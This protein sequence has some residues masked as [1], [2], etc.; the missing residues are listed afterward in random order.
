[1]KLNQRARGAVAGDVEPHESILAVVLLA[2][3]IGTGSAHSDGS[4]RQGG[5][6]LG[7]PY[8]RELGLD[9]DNPALRG[10][11]INSWL[12]VTDHQLL[13]HRPKATSIRP[14]PGTLIERLDRAGVRL[15]WFDTA[16]LGLS[17][18]V[19]HLELPDRTHVLSATMLKAQLR[20]KPFNDEPFLLVDAFGE[21]ATEVPQG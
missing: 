11:L 20:R 17:N 12:T 16:G 19:V 18:R 7:H 3:Q 2:N 4:H 9:L 15:R 6:A 13:F 21:M 1:M 5:S 8:A 10:M 14:T